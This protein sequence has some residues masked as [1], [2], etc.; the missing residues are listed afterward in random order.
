MR[1]F[2]PMQQLLFL[3]I[4]CVVCLPSLLSPTHPLD[5]GRDSSG[6]LATVE[7]IQRQ[8]AHGTFVKR[9]ITQ[10][11]GTSGQHAFV[12][13]DFDAGDQRGP[14]PGLNALANHGYISHT[15][16]VT[17]TETLQAVYEGPHV[18]SILS[19]NLFS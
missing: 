14:C 19:V 16:I 6:L 2:Y 9:D 18:A 10:P 11:V 4:S 12:P 15:G 13:P 8:V 17:F 5:L 7:Q 1:L 3:Q